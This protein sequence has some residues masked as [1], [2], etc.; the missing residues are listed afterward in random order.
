MEQNRGEIVSLYITAKLVN[1]DEQVS[2]Y[3]PVEYINSLEAS[4]I[5]GHLLYLKKGCIV[6]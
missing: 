6:M 1:S 4:D 5:P 3:Y 2:D